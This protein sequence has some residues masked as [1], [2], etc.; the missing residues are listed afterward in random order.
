LLKSIG[1]YLLE[2]KKRVDKALM[3]YLPS[4]DQEPV[5]LHQAIHYAVLG[6]N[7]K[8][9]RAA[10][11]Y[12]IT[13]KLGGNPKNADIISCIIE[14]AHSASLIHDDLPALDNADLRRGK[15]SAHKKFGEATAI[16]T[17]DAL[18]ALC[19]EILTKLDK[20]QLNDAMP[21]EIFRIFSHSIGS[22][23]IS[24]GELLDLQVQENVTP[25]EL[26]NIYLLK[27]GYGISASLLLGALSA[28]CQDPMILNNLEKFAHKLGVA[29]QI[30]DDIIGIETD[31]TVLG[32]QQGEDALNNKPTYPSLVGMPAAKERVR[33][34]YEEALLHLKETGIDFDRTKELAA[35]VIH[36]KF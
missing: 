21:N 34:L 5:Q 14:I 16:L 4:I 27:T 6:G 9:L 24:G 23:G 2:C 11:I 3:I 28:N 22:L 17:G 20:S 15:L 36:R 35:F 31:T 25:E 18:I 7:A 33:V 13:D 19:F 30:H 12:S 32:K 10:L 8:R 29:F 1:F 26:E